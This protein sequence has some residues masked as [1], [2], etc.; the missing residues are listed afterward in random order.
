MAFPEKIGKYDECWSCL[1]FPICKRSFPARDNPRNV[2]SH[3]R[4]V[5][6]EY[7]GELDLSFD[8]NDW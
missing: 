7:D 5:K 6:H 2:C 1:S 8:N 3:Y 4:P